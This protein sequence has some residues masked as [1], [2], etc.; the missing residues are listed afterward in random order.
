MACIFFI[1]FLK[2][3]RKR[4]ILKDK[5]KKK[6]GDKDAPTHQKVPTANTRSTQHTA[7]TSCIYLPSGSLA[8]SSWKTDADVRVPAPP[9]PT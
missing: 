7:N 2:K 3:E 9:F 5:R 1:L 4:K 6:Q 8:T